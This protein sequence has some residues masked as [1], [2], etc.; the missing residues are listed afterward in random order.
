MRLKRPPFV[1]K[2]LSRIVQSLRMRRLQMRGFRFTRTNIAPLPPHSAGYGENGITVILT[3]YKRHGYIAQQIQAI[4]NQTV[5]PVQIWLWCNNA[6]A[7]IPDFSNIVDRV[8]VSNHNWKFFGRFALA[9]LAQT[10]YVALFDDDVLPQPKWFENCLN[11]IGSGYDGILGG[12]G[13]LLPAAGGYAAKP[14]VG[15]NGE[16]LNEPKRVDLVGQAWFAR[17]AHLQYMWREEPYTYENGED[18]YLSY[19]AQKYGGLNTYVPPHPVADAS[20]WS[21]D[22]DFGQI[23][24]GS[25]VATYKTHD[26]QHIRS[27]AVDHYRANGWRICTEEER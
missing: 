2:Y 14:K 24:G 9:N 19:T 4:R 17:K 26:H 5:P 13:I 10:P 22:T 21:C 3:A 11:T 15:W 18:I 8:V 25:N 6:D 7:P 27:Q 20:M 12:S 23:A 1:K 16:K